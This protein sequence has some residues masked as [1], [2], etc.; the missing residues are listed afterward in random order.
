M[1]IL[2]FIEVVIKIIMDIKI[3]YVYISEIG[4]GFLIYR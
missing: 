4:F 1:I 2:S 3:M